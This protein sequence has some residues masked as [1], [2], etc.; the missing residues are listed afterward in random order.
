MNRFEELAQAARAAVRARQRR[1]PLEHLRELVRT[2]PPT[3]NAAA[4]L[5]SHGRAV[6]V[7]A[8]VKR[9]TADFADLTGVGDVAVLARFYEA[10]GAACVSVV[11]E[12]LRSHG[13]L[14]DLDAVR[15]AVDVPV[16]VND[17]VVTP[18]QV[19]EARAHG[20]DLLMLD[21]RLAPLILE[22]LVERTHSLGM[23]AVV[24]AHTRAEALTA[25]RLG[26]RAV[27]VDSRDPRNRRADPGRFAQVAEVVPAA[28]MRIAQGGVRGAHDVMEYARAGA[29]VVLV[30][31]ALIRSADPQQ[32][33]A[34][35]VAAG[36]HP[37]L[38]PATHREVF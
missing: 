25:L 14:E 17:L 29:D 22:S 31:E 20:A 8:E 34:E 24:E 30:G 13:A 15:G 21:A 9:A 4:V 33:V 18:Y 2:A 38:L 7:I 32:F 3:L 35:L 11:T 5:R 12:P 1:L 37:A 27:S 23:L 26:A 36:S 19:H 28:T 16:L 10:G 6:S